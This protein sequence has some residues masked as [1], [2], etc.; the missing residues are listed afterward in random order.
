M[1]DAVGRALGAEVTVGVGCR[2]CGLSGGD[3]G[4]GFVSIVGIDVSTEYLQKVAKR[5]TGRI[6]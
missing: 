1:L 3:F 5:S 6:Q 4:M 2:G